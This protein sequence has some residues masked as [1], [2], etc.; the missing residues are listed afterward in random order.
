MG[1]LVIKA[2]PSLKEVAEEYDEEPILSRFRWTLH[3]T[4]QHGVGSP[5]ACPPLILGI[6]WSVVPRRTAERYVAAEP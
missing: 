3:M 4:A 2:M 6:L 5:S 1:S